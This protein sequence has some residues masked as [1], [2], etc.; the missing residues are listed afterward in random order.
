MMKCADKLVG[1]W[2]V[3]A[4][5][6]V[7][8]ASLAAQWLNYPTAGVP[9][10]SS[11]APN[12][13]APTPKTADGKTDFSGIW[14]AEKNRPCDPE[15]CQDLQP[16]EQF[17][18]IAWG[19]KDGLPYQPWAADLVKARRAQF[20][21][22]DPDS[23]CLPQGI[24]K[25][26]TAPLLRKIIQL[27][28]LLVILNER[29]ATYRQIFLDG[30]PL[31]P[32]PAPSWRGYSTAKWDKDVLVVESN[33]FRDDLWLD[34]FGSPMTEAAKVTE[35]FRRV[36]YGRLEVEVTVDDPKA[37]TKPWTVKLVQLL[38]VNTELLDFFCLENEK[39]EPHLIGK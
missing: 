13:N 38:V 26:H 15:G 29:N 25:M 27:P 22:D 34:R 32:D 39:D 9:K 19:L 20:A 36:N 35:R 28:G 2:A 33:G 10:T 12:M 31:E 21:K 17:F 23:K 1:R 4:V 18:N 8:P 24:L 7:I 30:R 11:G 14:E 3:M 6:C 37:Y 16:G 5:L